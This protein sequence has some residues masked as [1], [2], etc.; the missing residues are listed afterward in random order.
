MKRNIALSIFA[1]IFLVL[2]LSV[3]SA[4]TDSNETTQARKDLIAAEICLEEISSASVPTSR[5][6]ESFIEA[7]Q[8]FE[9]QYILEQNRKK[10]NYEISIQRSLEVCTIKDAA[11]KANDELI[12]FLQTYEEEQRKINL[13]EMDEIVNEITTSF[14]DERFEDTIKLIDE[15]YNSLSEIEA[16]QTALNLFYQSTTATIGDFFKD[17]WIPIVT[18]LTI[19][20]IT[21]IIFWKTF[22]KARI[23]RKLRSLDIQ[24][25][26]LNQ[27][28]KKLQIGYFKTKVISETEFSIK[29]KRFKEMIRDIDRQKP[30]LR[31]DLLKTSKKRKKRSKKRK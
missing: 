4:I 3:T 2:T 14:T 19:I 29:L 10:P 8:L 27:L 31:E 17:N 24:K 23:H 7:Q 13:S 20:L 5:A 26:T 15:G 16:T 30:L 18:I 12:I 11:I 28:I 22:I 21:T 1:L 25:N 9:S 6:N